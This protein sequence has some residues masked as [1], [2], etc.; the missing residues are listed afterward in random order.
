M[1]L[2]TPALTALRLAPAVVELDD[3]TR[4]GNTGRGRCWLWQ[5]LLS[6]PCTAGL[7]SGAE[8]RERLGSH[9]DRMLSSL[10][11]GGRVRECRLKATAISVHSSR[12]NGV[13][14]AAV[15]TKSAGICSRSA[16][17]SAVGVATRK[18]SLKNGS[19]MYS[20]GSLLLQSATHRNSLCR[21]LKMASPPPIAA[22]TTT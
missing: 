15:P 16:V 11:Q 17:Y 10:R 1:D 2:A 18:C 13:N 4:C 21:L 19:T 6:L 3:C 22:R 7:T 9:L 20:T 8:S 14:C 12:T 5:Q